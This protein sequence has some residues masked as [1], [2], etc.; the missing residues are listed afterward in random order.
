LYSPL[1]IQVSGAAAAPVDLGANMGDQLPLAF[2]VPQ[3]VVAGAGPESL[4][5]GHGGEVPEDPFS[6][7]SAK[8]AGEGE[9]Q[10]TVL[11]CFTG[12]RL[13]AAEPVFFVSGL[14][15]FSTLSCEYAISR[16]F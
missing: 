9:A 10:A 1:F 16:V 4:F 2:Q 6:V 15:L 3:Q 13:D 7:C 14:S 12:V 11:G 5:Q 8:A